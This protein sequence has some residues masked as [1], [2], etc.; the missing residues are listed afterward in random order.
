M[1]V[2]CISAILAFFLTASYAQTISIIDF[3]KVKDNKL[4]EALY[5]YENNWK[6]YREIALK[7]EY[8]IGYK[9]L[10]TNP[11]SLASF[12]F[13]LITEYADSAQHALAE[14]RFNEIIKEIRPTGPKLLN[15]YKPNEFRINLFNR[16]AR[17]V[18]DSD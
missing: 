6:V 10:T 16:R 15:G 8:I 18:F 14:E 3:V 11:D 13:M 5:F 1:K 17:S 12:D 7:K 2:I 9:F 4:R